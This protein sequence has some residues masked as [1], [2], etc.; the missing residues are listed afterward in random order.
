MHFLLFV[1]LVLGSPWAWLRAAFVRL[2]SRAGDPST[3]VQQSVVHP[4][5]RCGV[6]LSASLYLLNIWSLHSVTLFE[7]EREET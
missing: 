1:I 3:D 7:I 2:D 4:V 5:D 6:P